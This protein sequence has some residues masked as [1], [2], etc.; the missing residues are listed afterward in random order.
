[1]VMGGREGMV[2]ESN[3]YGR[4]LEHVFIV[5]V[6]CVYVSYIYGVWQAS[7]S[8]PSPGGQKDR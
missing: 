4:L 1:M 6:L 5:F 2:C 3:V 8:I 7:G